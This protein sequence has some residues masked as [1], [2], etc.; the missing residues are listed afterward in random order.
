MVLQARKF[1]SLVTTYSGYTNAIAKRIIRKGIPVFSGQ[2]FAV[3]DRNN[4]KSAY[5]IIN[6]RNGI[7]ICRRYSLEEANELAQRWNLEYE[8]DVRDGYRTPD[9]VFI[10][11][12]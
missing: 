2:F 3:R 5:E 4:E 8:R 7:V 10:K 12:C 1:I 11:R 6:T 9:G